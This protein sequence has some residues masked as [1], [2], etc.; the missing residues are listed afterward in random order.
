M[1]MEMEMELDS[2][3]LYLM[4]KNSTEDIWNRN[5]MIPSL[6][7]L[8]IEPI[9]DSDFQITLERDCYTTSYDKPGIL[10]DTKKFIIIKSLRKYKT[11]GSNSLISYY[12]KYSKNIIEKIRYINIIFHNKN[13]LYLY[14]YINFI[15]ATKFEKK[16]DNFLYIFNVITDIETFNYLENDKFE[17]TFNYE[18]EYKTFGQYVNH[19]SANINFNHTKKYII[20]LYTSSDE[21]MRGIGYKRAFVNKLFT[22]NFDYLVHFYGY[23]NSEEFSV[24]TIDDNIS[25]VMYVGKNRRLKLPKGKDPEKDEYVEQNISVS[26]I[27]E[28]LLR[29]I[30]NY[31]MVGII[32]GG[33]T[34]QN[35][36]DESIGG[37]C[38][39]YKLY[40]QKVF[41]LQE[42]NIV[43]CPYFSRCCEDIFFNHTLFLQGNKQKGSK[44]IP[45]MCLKLNNYKL[46]FGHF[47]DEDNE[48]IFQNEN[49]YK[50]NLE[51]SIKMNYYETIYYLLF[52]Y[53]KINIIQF[54][55]LAIFGKD[56]ALIVNNKYTLIKYKSDSKYISYQKILFFMYVINYYYYLY[57]NEPSIDF[58]NEIK[59]IF[60]VDN[61]KTE[62]TLYTNI[63]SQIVYMYDYDF[64]KDFLL[65]NNSKSNIQNNCNR[66]FNNINIRVT[67]IENLFSEVILKKRERSEKVEVVKNQKNQKNQKN[68]NSKKSRKLDSGIKKYSKN[69]KKSIKKN[70]KKSVKKSVNNSRRAGA[71]PRKK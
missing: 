46:F 29:K 40:L 42:N 6:K 47:K 71:K 63:G 48:I 32:K 61:K 20:D 23:V 39:I 30:E 50:T 51:I 57:L 45:E 4:P 33:G 5:L 59:N 37:D 1:D 22:S 60:Q 68:R 18:T 66:L 69:R 2:E 54:A 62:V 31:F 44:K 16:V 12:K 9:I 8:L 53:G 28:I 56:D 3:D 27:Y 34:P 11:P 58:K 52:Y 55:P 7:G 26:E 19:K 24:L 17:Y 43:Y 25:S 35:A 49:I 21:L 15:L 14:K 10:F 41:K 13:L 64:Y 65:N 67:N 70:V 36:Q 38:A